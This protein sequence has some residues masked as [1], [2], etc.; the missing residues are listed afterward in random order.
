MKIQR[1][2]F[3]VWFISVIP[4]FFMNS[5]GGLVWYSIFNALHPIVIIVIIIWSISLNAQT[6]ER[7]SGK[8]NSGKP[9]SGDFNKGTELSD[10]TSFLD[11]RS[12]ASINE[13]DIDEADMNKGANAKDSEAGFS[14]QDLSQ[15][16][17]TK[18][19][20]NNFKDI[21]KNHILENIIL[22]I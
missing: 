15:R 22:G 6:L 3:A 12:E 13:G 10:Y 19:Q 5:E 8:E 20:L 4:N 21:V 9:G 14:D 7:H 18:E 11:D 16:L 17:F 2:Y 1:V